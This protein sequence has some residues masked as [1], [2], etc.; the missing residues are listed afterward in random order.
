[1]ACGE[2]LRF[3]L[4][5]CGLK[6]SPRDL[7]AEARAADPCLHQFSRLVHSHETDPLAYLSRAAWLGPEDLFYLGFH[8]VEGKGPERDFGAGALRLLVKRKPASKLAKDAKRKLASAG[9]K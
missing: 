8:F 7:S 6:V 1:P 2:G 9:M 3:E 4:A 5:A